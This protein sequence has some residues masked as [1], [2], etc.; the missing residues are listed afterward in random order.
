MSD[1]E[2]L[3]VSSNEKQIPQVVENNRNQMRRWNS[4]SQLSCLQNRY[5]PQLSYT[6]LHQNSVPTENSA[7]PSR[8][9]CPI[10]VIPSSIS[11]KILSGGEPSRGTRVYILKDGETRTLS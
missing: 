8:D 2:A 11:V 3:G 6:A 9:S 7:I 1:V 5:F 4:W 10:Q